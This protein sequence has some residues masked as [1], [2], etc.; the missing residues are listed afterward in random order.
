MRVK[1]RSNAPRFLALVKELARF[2]E[3]YAQERNI[4]R[5][6][7]YKDDALV[8]LASTKPKDMADLGRSR[9]L[10][11]EAR[12][13]EIANGILEAVHRAQ[14]MPKEQ[15][16]SQ[17]DARPSPQVNPALADLLRVLLK[18]KTEASGVASKLIATSAELDA[19]ASG[20]RNVPALQGWRREVFG[21]DALRLCE[22]RVA[23]AAKGKQVQIIEL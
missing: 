18:A 16:P 5:S 3:S 20:E 8:E 23:L 17:D 1:T 6:R 15:L 12:K 2:R 9:L 19:L 14:S 21:H 11:R 7:V 10:L 4:P 13:G 22:G